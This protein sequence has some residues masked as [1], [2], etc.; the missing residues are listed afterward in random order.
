[1]STISKSAV[2]LAA[3]V[4]LGAG[5][6]MGAAPS[7]EAACSSMR[8]CSM[9][10]AKKIVAGKAVYG[11][12]NASVRQLQISL[13]NVGYKVVVDGRF[14]SQTRATV[15]KYQA[16]RGLSVNGRVDAATLSALRT[17]KRPVKKAAVKVTSVT[18]SVSASSDAQQAVSFAYAKLGSPYRYGSTGPYSFDCSGLTQAAYRAAGV[19]IP[20]TSYS[21][22]GGLRR[23]SLSN[24]K[25][26]DILGFYGGGHVG[27]YIGNGYVI[28]APRTG[29]VVR[30]AKLSSMRPTSAVRPA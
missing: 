13:R 23:V 6:T 17:G 4:A 16:L 25:P 7:A 10:A 29:D 28:H 27:I 15:K 2:A 11:A 9:T 20:R 1:M 30:K 19:S 12:S 24:L 3:S 26:G 21:Q 14:G 5:M 22:L 8:V 18:S